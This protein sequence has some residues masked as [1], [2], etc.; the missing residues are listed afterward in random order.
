[1]ARPHASRSINTLASHTI[2]TS[3]TL[4]CLFACIC[5]YV[6]MYVCTYVRMY[7]CVCIS[8]YVYV[9]MYVCMCV[10]VYTYICKYIMYY[11]LG[12][13]CLG[14]DGRRCDGHHHVLYL[15]FLFTW[16]IG[17]VLWVSV[18]SDVSEWVWWLAVAP[19]TRHT[20]TR[21]T[22]TTVCP[23]VP[24]RSMSDSRVWLCQSHPFNPYMTTPYMTM[25]PHLLTLKPHTIFSSAW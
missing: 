19:T 11:I 4:V 1:M 10:C 9:C 7:V 13:C 17:D 14:D 23:C 12:V 3:Q 21:H 6:C 18:V 2:N 22:H 15:I 16:D 20:H 8:M 5:M 24:A 25:L